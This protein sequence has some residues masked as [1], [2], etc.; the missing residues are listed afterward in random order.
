MK[1]NGGSQIRVLAVLILGAGLVVPSTGWGQAAKGKKEKKEKTSVSKAPA[2]EEGIEEITV[3][4]QKREEPLQEAPISVTALTSEKLEEKGVANVA[5]LGQSAPNVRITTN[6]GSPA[7]TTISMRGL[8]QGDPNAAL[9]P[10]VGMYVDGVYISKIIGSNLDLEDLER[11]EVLR[12][13]QGTLYGRNAVGGAVNFITKKPTEERSIT[14]KTEVG[15]FEAFNGRIT[16]NV[17]LIGK[18]AGTN[19]GAL[20]ALSGLEGLGTLSLRQSVGYKTHDGLYRNTGTGSTN[21]ADLNRVYSTTAL[22]WEPTEDITLDYS[23]EYHRYRDTP[24]AFQLTY[25]YPGSASDKIW[26]VPVGGG[27]TIPAQGFNLGPYVQTNRVNAIAN[28]AMYKRDFS[29]NRLADDGNNRLHTLAGEWHLGELGPLGDVSVKSISSFRSFSYQSDQ[30][31]DGTP[32]HVADFSQ[33][34]DIQHWSE[35]LQWVGTLPRI[36]YVAGA[37]YYGDYGTQNEDQVIFGKQLVQIGPPEFV[38][39]TDL[40]SNLPYKNVMKTQSFA[41]YGQ[42]TWTPPILNDKLRVT[43]GIRYTEEHV[44]MDHAWFSLSSSANAFRAAKSKT[45]GGTDGISPMGDISYQWTDDLMT[46]FRISRGFRAGGFTPTAPNRDAFTSFKPETLLSYEAGFKS[47]WLDNR[48]R[49]NADGFFSSYRDFQVSLFHPSGQS[50][51]FSQQTNAD[52]AEIWGM[53]FEAAAIP[54]RG[55]E[56]SVNYS[57]L[58]PQYTKWIEPQFD[59]NGNVTGPGVDVTHQ[60]AFAHT[61]H[62]QAT[63]GLTYTA[64]RTTT[65]TFSAHVDTYWQDRVVFIANNQTAGAQADEG[66][67]YALANGR[68]AYTGIPLQKGSLDVALFGHNLFD[69]KYRT[70]GIDFGSGLGYA[71]NIYGDPRTFGLQMVYN[72]SAS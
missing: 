49:V 2:T 28:N 69:R 44:R 39:P 3:T 32:V 7:S 11:V 12:G 30:D 51:A 26:N 64:P 60:R 61:P 35:E 37:Y 20:S 27:V 42:A 17:P 14:I 48:L 58:A 46:Y 62:N 47:Q 67:A 16:A 19:G 25:V 63:V 24:T 33:V 59:V 38:P 10:A 65:G 5:D 71:G 70:Y 45:F 72:F 13:P 54:V 57:F 68:L 4:A 15:N 66:W 53:E 18:N 29:L 43:A 52:K 56:A 55:V 36:H 6:P 1:A 50:G 31:L 41:P 22:R 9:D 23:F 21:F 8:T 40:T 34:N